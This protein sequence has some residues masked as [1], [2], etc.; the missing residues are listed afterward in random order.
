M[1]KEALNITYAKNLNKQNFN[2]IINL[3]IDSK[4]NVK[5]ILNTY[6]YIFD[7][8]IER[9]SG[10]AVLS[11]KLGVKVLYIDTDNITNTITETQ[12]FSETILD[13]SITSDC[14]INLT[15][16]S[17]LCEVLSNDGNLK[18]G[19]NISFV[20]IVYVN[21]AMNNNLSMD[22]Q[23]ISKNSTFTTNTI[24]NKIDTSFNY[25]TNFETQNNISKILNSESVFCLTNLTSQD[26]Y[27]I[28]EGK[29]FSTIIY[30]T[31]ENEEI[32]IKSISDVFNIKTDIELP[33]LKH[34]SI[35]DLN[36]RIDC[37]AENITTELE[38][39]NNI[40]TL[41]H[42]IKVKGLELKEITVDVVEDLYSTINEIELNK[43]SREFVCATKKSCLS[44]AVVGEINLNKDESAI[45]E[46]ISNTNANAEI[47]N[48][49]VKNNSLHF[50]GIVNSTV[51]YIDEAK[52]LKSK[53]V[54]FPFV[55][56]T[57]IEIENLPTNHIELSLNT[58][59]IKA[60]RGTIIELEYELEICAYLYENTNKEII[61]SITLGKSLDFSQYDY[62][63]YIAKPNETLWDLCKRIKCHPNEL[64]KCNKNL[65]SAFVGGE[66]IIIK[67]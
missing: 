15:S 16:I 8:K 53:I 66:K 59:K 45:E 19:C 52:E 65:P 43:S 50:E 56:N 60:R 9:A 34:D 41:T 30:E 51:I 10:K 57:K 23:T 61:D 3:Q 20:P 42:L 67:R 31:T 5:T 32:K 18:V 28:I 27:A 54:E 39:D 35:L 6:C 12:P 33:N 1:E 17:C 25:T 36:F 64:N 62:Q 29:M 44:E 47:T 40:I 2:S 63:I 4:V 14:F 7:E 49:Y 11:G 26:G 38:D 55:V 58:S 37:S 13:N 46:I 24:V 22:E 48:V 21:L